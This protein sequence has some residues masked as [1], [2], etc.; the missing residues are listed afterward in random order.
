MRIINIGTGGKNENSAREF[1]SI[2]PFEFKFFSTSFFFAE[3]KMSFY[4]KVFL[5]WVAL[6]NFSDKLFRNKMK[7]KMTSWEN[8]K[9]CWGRRASKEVKFSWNFW[10]NA[11]ERTKGPKVSFRQEA[12]FRRNFC[13]NPFRRSFICPRPKWQHKIKITF[14]ISFNLR[15]GS[16]HI[17]HIF[18]PAA[19]KKNR[20]WLPQS[21]MLNFLFYVLCFPR[22]GFSRLHQ[23][24]GWAPPNPRR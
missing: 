10:W 17:T 20:S 21:L 2:F 11:W 15:E 3:W 12:K 13:G 16:F 6:M 24:T 9:K 4:W 18:L 19:E 5:A 7:G 23:A 22:K 1:S 14:A 8:G